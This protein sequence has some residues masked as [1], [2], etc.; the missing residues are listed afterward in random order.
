[1]TESRLEVY[2]SDPANRYSGGT[3]PEAIRDKH[4]VIGA[5]SR[6]GETAAVAMMAN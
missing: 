6:E 5:I 4:N 2:P 1:M 3:K